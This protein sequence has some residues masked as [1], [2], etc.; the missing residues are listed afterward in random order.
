MKLILVHGTYGHSKENWFPW[1]K[2]TLG[3]IIIPDF[4]GADNPKLDEWKK[5]INKYS[6][7]ENTILIGHSLGCPF[8]LK[9]LEEK[10]VKACIFLAGFIGKL[11]LDIDKVNENI[12][13]KGFDFQRINEN[14]K[15][16]VM[17]ISDNDPYISLIKSFELR[18][19]IS[20]KLI[21]IKGAGHFNEKSGYTEFSRILTEIKGFV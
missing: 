12:A 9:L 8:I 16:F 6:I 10:E 1:L 18:N 4:P 20:A 21:L 2:K 5:E 11:N 3:D 19:K 13:D 17:F 15:N 7:D 14:C